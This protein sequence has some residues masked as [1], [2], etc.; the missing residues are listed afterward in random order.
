MILGADVPLPSWARSCFGGPHLIEQARLVSPC[1]N[2]APL[3]A[4]IDR[5]LLL[6]LLLCRAAPLQAG[7]RYPESQKR[8]VHTS[9][10][11]SRGA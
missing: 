6:G 10:S 2:S 5:P 4:G 11:I 3:P 7:L 1:A 8:L 9:P